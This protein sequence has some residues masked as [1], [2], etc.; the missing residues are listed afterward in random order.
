MT[1]SEYL[2][3]FTGVNIITK[4]SLSVKAEITWNVLNGDVIYIVD[5]STL[6]RRLPIKNVINPLISEQINAH[7]TFSFDTV[8]D[9]K[10][11]YINN[12]NIIEVDDD[13]FQVG[14]IVKQRETS[15][16]M[17]VSCEH[18]SYK[19]L[20]KKK[21][22]LPFT[23]AEDSPRNL[24]SALL[25]G[26][27]FS[28]GTVEIGGSYYIKP[29]SDNIRGALIELANLVGGEL[30][31]EK[32][33]VHLVKRRGADNGLEFRLGENLIGVTEEIDTTG[34]EPKVSLG[35]DVLV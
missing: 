20:D 31:W 17:S 12:A 11:K 29:K 9:D 3:E 28:V 16:S 13:Y 35:V 25:S 22:P 34:E 14:R 24:M 7:Y 18:V 30:I 2:S 6:A 27:P 15:V 26:T 1:A 8:F 23:E 4:S 33:T 10:T 5:P 19:L 32:F 21:Y